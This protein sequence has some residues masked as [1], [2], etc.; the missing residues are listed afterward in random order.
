MKVLIQMQNYSNLCVY[1]GFIASEHLIVYVSCCHGNFVD[2]KHA[3]IC[4]NVKL[5]GSHFTV[6]LVVNSVAHTLS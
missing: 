5:E 6:R 4:L 3:S 1:N 2:R